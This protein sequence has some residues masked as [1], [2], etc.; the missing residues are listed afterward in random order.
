MLYK[1]LP[2]CLVFV[3]MVALRQEEAGDYLK[4]TE[5]LVLRQPGGSIVQWSSSSTKCIF[6]TW[7]LLFIDFQQIIF[8]LTQ[9]PCNVTRKGLLKG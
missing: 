1:W 7:I 4:E 3:G 8:W 5:I 9:P 2:V 6:W